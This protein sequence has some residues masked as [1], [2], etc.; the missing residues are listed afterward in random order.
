MCKSTSTSSLNYHPNA[1]NMVANMRS[2]LS[3]LVSGFSHLSSKEGKAT[4]L[5]GDMDVSILMF[6]VQEDEED[7]LK[8]REPFRRK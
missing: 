2:R 6:H 8:D 7:K 1:P 3:L 5:I 4:M